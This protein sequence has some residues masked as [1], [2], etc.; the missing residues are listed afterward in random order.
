[1]ALTS[2][3]HAK[4]YGLYPR[5]GSIGRRRGRR[6]RAVGPDAQ[7]HDLAEPSCT[8]ART[9]RRGRAFEV[10]GWPVRTLLRGQAVFE[11]GKVTGRPGGGE[12]LKR[13]LS[14]YAVPRGA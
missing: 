2:T 13:G 1:M 5:K 3:N 10:T 7:G 12:F 14:P 9:T 6:H 8:T 11:D 4:I